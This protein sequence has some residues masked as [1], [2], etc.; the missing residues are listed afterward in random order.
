[1]VKSLICALALVGSLTAAEAV[2]DGFEA[3]SWSDWKSKDAVGSFSHNKELGNNAPGSLEIK[4]GP[5]DSGKS[6]FTFTKR[7]P[8]IP[9]KTYTA[10]VFV[11]ARELDPAAIVSLSFRGQDKQNKFLSTP[12]ATTTITGAK[13]PSDIW[14]QLTLTFRIPAEGEWLKAAQVLCLL[15]VRNTPNGTVYFDDFEFFQDQ[16][17]FITKI[18]PTWKNDKA[19][20]KFSYNEAEGYK[21]AP[22]AL[23]IDIGP[24]NPP[25]QTLCFTGQFAVQPGKTYIGKVN[26]RGAGLSP[27]AVVSLAF[28][29][30]DAQRKF[31]PTKT[32]SEQL[33]GDLSEWR[34]I[35]LIFKVPNEGDWAR[36]GYLMTL[37]TA[38]NSPAGKVFFSDFTFSEVK[39]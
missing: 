34:Q 30:L 39:D 9:G 19:V 20:G 27:D 5:N 13:T 4:V 7:F 14:K 10:R 6:S 33:L 25:E 17:R 3:K 35:E 24:N 32:V 26:V 18:W 21:T 15:G 28:R 2:K 29:G 8:V 38:K 16:D 12:T 37:L 31:L 22:G 23:I 11:Q 36:A 1:M